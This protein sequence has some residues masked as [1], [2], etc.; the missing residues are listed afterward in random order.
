ML[1][2]L[3]TGT[4]TNYEYRQRRGTHRQFQNDRPAI[5]REWRRLYGREIDRRRAE[6]KRRLPRRRRQEEY[7]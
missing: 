1:T 3:P 7:D 5:L 2:E 4:L 6:R